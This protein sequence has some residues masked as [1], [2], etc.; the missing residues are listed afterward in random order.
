M[1]R[2]RRYSFEDEPKLNKK[3]V[4]AVVLAVL[5]IIMVIV[6]INKVLSKDVKSSNKDKQNYYASFLNGKWGVINSKGE[7]VISTQYD[8]MIVVPN[9]SE[10]VF[11]CTYDVNYEDGSYKVWPWQCVKEGKVYLEKYWYDIYFH[12]SSYCSNEYF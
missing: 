1:S 7:D 8:E 9:N 12:I 3:K 6:A 11:I 2:G 5:V 10:D 4:L